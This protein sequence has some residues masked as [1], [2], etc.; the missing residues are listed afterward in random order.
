MSVCGS[1]PKNLARHIHG[2]AGCHCLGVTMMD[3]MSLYLKSN[4]SNPWN[5]D[6]DT[7]CGSDGTM[8]SNVSAARAD[9]QRAVV[10]MIGRIGCIF[11]PVCSGFFMKNNGHFLVM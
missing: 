3:G 10:M 7:G 2:W 8:L 4:R 1:C 9:V 6:F 5:D 11:F